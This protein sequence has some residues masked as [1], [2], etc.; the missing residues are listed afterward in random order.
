[1]C[2]KIL[3]EVLIYFLSLTTAFETA[4]GDGSYMDLTTCSGKT[5]PFVWWLQQ[6]A[7]S[8]FVL[9]QFHHCFLFAG[10]IASIQ[11]C[12]LCKRQIK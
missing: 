1:M 8:R 11:I 10:F 6:G 7:S 4:D 2:L 5:Y 9:K 12:Q 3:N